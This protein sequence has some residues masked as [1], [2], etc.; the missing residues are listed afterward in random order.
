M[1]Y[2]ILC[3]KRN[4][5]VVVVVLSSIGTFR[6]DYEYETEC[7]FESQTSD[8]SRA[9]VVHVGFRQGVQLMGCMCCD[10]VAPVD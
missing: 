10:N 1:L 2:N 4:K 3:I 9:L 7:D 6:L 5:M 8:L